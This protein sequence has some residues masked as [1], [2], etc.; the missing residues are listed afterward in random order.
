MAIIN[1]KVKLNTAATRKNDSFVKKGLFAVITI[2]DTHNHSLNTAEALKFLPASDC[3]EKFMD[4]FSDDMGV[5]EACKYHEGILQSEE[6]FTD[7]HMANSQIN[8]PLQNCT[9]LA[10]SMASSKFGSKNW[11]GFN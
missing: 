4:Y 9:A 10:Q 1:I 6:K 11:S 2:I 7:E 3:K 8:P 5:A